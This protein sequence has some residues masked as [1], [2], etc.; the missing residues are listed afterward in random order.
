MRPEALDALA[1][2][3]STDT[4]AG[5]LLPA[6]V[7]DAD[8]QRVLML[9]WMSR[10][11][12]QTTLDTGWV[13]FHSRSRAQL[14]TKGETSGPAWRWSRSRQTATAT[15][16]WCRRDRRT[17]LPSRQRQ[18]LRRRTGSVLAELDAIVARRARERRRAA[19]P[20]DCSSRCC[21]HRAEGRRGGR[22]GRACRRRRRR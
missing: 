2:V 22:G 1:W 11:A 7:Q 19:I 17:D 9:G 4:R 10:E 5:G 15:R 12:L 14:W 13:T 20:R 18:L 21:A 8:D 6:I 16:C 3:Q